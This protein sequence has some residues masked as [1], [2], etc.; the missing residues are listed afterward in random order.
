MGPVK[1]LLHHQQN[2]LGDQW[3][4]KRLS[5]NAAGIASTPSKHGHLCGRSKLPRPDLPAPAS[6]FDLAIC[7]QSGC[8]SALSAVAFGMG[9]RPASRQTDGKPPAGRLL[10]RIIHEWA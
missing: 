6:A 9:S 10:A 7:V 5:V 1:L 4:L 3:L 8:I 2:G